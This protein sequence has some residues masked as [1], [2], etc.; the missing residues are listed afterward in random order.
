MKSRAVTFSCDSFPSKAKSDGFDV[1]DDTFC[2]PSAGLDD[3]GMRDQ[4]PNPESVGV[5][6]SELYA[7]FLRSDG[8]SGELAAMK[9]DWLRRM[10]L[11]IVDQE[12][13]Y[14][15]LLQAIESHVAM[16]GEASKDPTHLKNKFI[17]AETKKDRQEMATDTEEGNVSE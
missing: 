13:K 12:L 8:H 5:N 6:D 17:E 1:F 2:A 11:D 3:A 10:R 15:K 7:A 16:N 9:N 4:V 14:R